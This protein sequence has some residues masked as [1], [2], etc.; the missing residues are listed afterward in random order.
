MKNISRNIIYGLAF[1]VLVYMALGFW[2]SAEGL[3]EALS[4][5][6]WGYLPILLLIAFSNYLVRFIKWQYYLK[7][8]KINIPIIDSLIIFFSGFS[9]TITP[10]KMGE[11]VKSFFLKKGFNAPM[12]QTAPIVFA[13]R[14]SDLMAFL[15]ISAIGAYGFSYGKNVIWVIFILIILLISVIL[16][17]PIGLFLFNF[18]SKIKVISKYASRIM[19][20][21]ETSYALL[22]PKRL[23]FPLF[24]SI[25]AWSFEALDFYLILILLKL[26]VSAFAA[27]FIYCFSTIVG[28]VMMLPGGL[29]VTDGSIAGLLK[30]LSI[31]TG[32]AAFATILIRAVTLWFAVLI[33]L[34][35]L[36][37]AEKRYD[38]SNRQHL[39]IPHK[40]TR[41]KIKMLFH[42]HSNSS[43]DGRLASGDIIYYCREN[44]IDVV[45]IT[46]HNEIDGAIRTEK[47]SNGN[48]RVI[49][50]EE[51]KTLDGEVIGL[52]LKKKVAKGL[53]LKKTIT[54][55]KKQGGLVCLPHPGDKIRRS[56]I[57]R[58]I[59][60]NIIDSI[61]IIEVFNSRNLFVSSNKFAN[62]LAEKHRK[63]KIAGADA[64]L[65]IELSKAI[66]VIVDY[67][68]KEEF[69]QSLKSGEYV[70]EKTNIFVQ[71]WCVLLKK[72]KII[73]EKLYG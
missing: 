44:K 14:L 52:F 60:E 24:L 5:F 67:E 36:F 29:G 65:K 4:N 28:A 59:S 53:S 6:A 25:I 30:F 49:I 34:C 58:K 10:G 54:E 57:S 56:A 11:V 50:G 63:A 21:Y 70:G 68:N 2:G 39:P 45:A 38:R 64:H 61:D 16:I 46:D 20:I 48:P 35:F 19:N 18:L 62:H 9:L 66:N 7:V 33:G 73:K 41:G 1:A 22:L 13:D 15:L 47:M 12:S 26:D 55:I 31:E 23:L 27:F 43:D 72:A 40:E 17:R 42:I 8:L 32:I 69:F 51:I 37:I 3:S 71:G